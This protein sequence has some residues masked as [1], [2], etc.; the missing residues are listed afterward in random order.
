MY[1]QKQYWI[2][3][4]K[5]VGKNRWIFTDRQCNIIRLFLCWKKQFNG[6]IEKL[7]SHRVNDQIDLFV[8]L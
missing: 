8:V 2:N 1:G 4:V 5:K 6:W 7:I 3:Y